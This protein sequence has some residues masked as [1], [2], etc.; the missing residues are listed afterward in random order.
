[1]FEVLIINGNGYTFKDPAQLA[2]LPVY[3]L[4]GPWNLCFL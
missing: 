3:N 4:L 2:E 1:M